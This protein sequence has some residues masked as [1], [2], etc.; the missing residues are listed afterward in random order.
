M[1]YTLGAYVL[2]D[3]ATKRSATTG[4]FCAFQFCLK[5]VFPKKNTVLYSFYNK[6]AAL[7]P[8]LNFLR[9]FEKNS[10][11]FIG[12][13]FLG[14]FYFLDVFYGKYVFPDFEKLELFPKNYHYFQKKIILFRTCNYFIR[15]LRRICYNLVMRHLQN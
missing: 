10:Q 7:S 12:N 15:I 8:L 3:G 11:T 1:P 14:K 6:I 9:F 13:T 5:C 2:F 4:I